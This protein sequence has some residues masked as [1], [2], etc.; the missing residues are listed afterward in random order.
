MIAVSIVSHGH[1]T[2]VTRLVAR[3]LDCPE[4]GRVIVTRNRPEPLDLP[5][6]PRIRRI[7]N[8]HPSGFGANHNAAFAHADAPCFCVL[9]PDIMLPDNP[10]P[11]L[12]DCLDASGAALAVPHIV[13]PDGA[14]EDSVRRFPTPWRLLHKSLAGA[15]GEHRV[16][17]PDWAAG[18]FM[19]WRHEAFAQLGGFN[20]R[21]FLYYEDVDLCTRAWRAGLPIAYCREATAIHDARRESHRK[22][23]FLRWHLASMARY[24]LTQSW[25]LPR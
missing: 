5:D 20:E 8:P 3:L 10:F 6:D 1:G 9:N 7:D 16:A 11:A 18:M 12:L 25:R 2:M 15:R 19:L 17:R 24:F 22:L 4:V 13:A 14:D 21:Y 23:R